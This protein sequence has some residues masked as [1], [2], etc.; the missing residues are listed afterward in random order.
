[1]THSA[2]SCSTLPGGASP[3]IA[4]IPANFEIAMLTVAQDRASARA[5]REAGILLP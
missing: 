5:G 4:A 2:P 1:M 3:G